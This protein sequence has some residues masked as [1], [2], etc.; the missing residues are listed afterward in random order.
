LSHIVTINLE[1]RDL[2]AIQAACRR[3]G[4]AEPVQGKTSLFSGEATGWAVQLPDWVYP[5]VCDLAAGKLHYDNFAG[6]WGE[7]KELDRFLQTYAVEKAK[8]EAQRQGHRVTE[9]LL[10]DGS[11]QLSIQLQGGAL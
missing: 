2:A 7:Q 3:L 4:L 5:V 8:R 11:I 6:R 9:A 10:T 1:I